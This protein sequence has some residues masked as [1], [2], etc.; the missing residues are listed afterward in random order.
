M[1]KQDENIFRAPVWYPNLAAF[2]F[3]TM[4]VKLTQPEISLLAHGVSSGNQ[5]RDILKRLR[6]P[7]HML[8]GNCFAFVDT[9]APTDTSRFRDKH[10]AV[11]SPQSA[12]KYLAR[13]L[14]VREAAAAGKVEYV[15][16]RPFRRM[17]NTREFRLFIYKGE[18]KAMSQ[19]NLVRH[20]RR[21]EGMKK[22]YWKLAQKFMDEAGWLLP[23]HNLVV[24]IYITSDN[25][26]LVIDLNPWGN[27]TDPKMMNT[28]DRDWEEETGVVLMPPPTRINGDVNV[29]F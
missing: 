10:G 27:G 18:L 2:T 11:H 24:D 1:S 21:L 20:F 25:Q 26:V 29:S 17:N 3:P 16:L 12:W 13:S 28:W 6:L 23:C 22:D 19:Y 9:V 8:P 15:C 7:M 5:V 4:F 14:K